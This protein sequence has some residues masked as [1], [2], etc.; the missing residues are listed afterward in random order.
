MPFDEHDPAAL[1]AALRSPEPGDAAPI[2]HLARRSGALDD[3]SSYAYALLCTHFSDTCIVAEE[4][5]A[6]VGFV[7]GYRPPRAAD[8]L[9]VWQVTVA[10]SH[11]GRGLGRK[12][13]SRLVARDALADVR[14]LEA[15]VTPSNVASR[16]LFTAAAR[17][18][19]APCDV[20][21][22]FG[23][24]VF[25]ETG[26]EPEDLFRIGPFTTASPRRDH[27]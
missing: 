18:L 8:T 23:P 4:H 12:M 6:I 7:V 13:L 24:D 26:H 16:R 20:Q 1:H 5:D 14:F 21:R 2:W 9:F 27:H 11:R 22:F 10:S 15:T 25:P 19:D 3:N 17:E